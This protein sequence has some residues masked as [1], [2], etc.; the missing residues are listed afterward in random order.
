MD[1]FLS[2][3]FGSQ[4]MNQFWRLVCLMTDLLTVGE[5]CYA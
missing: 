5:V 2:K 1:Y 3:L 4:Q